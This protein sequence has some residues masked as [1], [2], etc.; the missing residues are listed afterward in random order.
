MRS[1]YFILGKMLSSV[2]ADA[3]AG[4]STDIQLSKDSETYPE[5]A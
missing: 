2:S 1:R 5:V 4:I 3:K